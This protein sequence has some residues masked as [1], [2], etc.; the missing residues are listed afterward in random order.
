MSEE[1]D[2]YFQQVETLMGVCTGN[3]MYALKMAHKNYFRIKSGF[4]EDENP[5]DVSRELCMSIN[6][7]VVDG[8]VDCNKCGWSWELSDGGDDPYVCH[9]CGNKNN[10][11]NESVINERSITDNPVRTV[12]K[13]LI[14]IIK[15]QKPGIYELPDFIKRNKMEY[16]FPKLPLFSVVLDLDFQELDVPY[17]LDAGHYGEVEGDDEEGYYFDDEIEIA[18][19]INPKDYPQNLYDILADLNDSV[20]HE[21]EHAYQKNFRREIEF[22]DNDAPLDKEYYK[23]EK[24]IPA[25]IAGF[26]RIVKLR[27]EPVEKVIRD[28]FYRHKSTHELPN[29]DIEELVVFLSDKYRDFYGQ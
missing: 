1:F 19:V 18:L 26:R 7:S 25:E 11:L 22:E 12:V 2:D 20:R 14:N 9:K 16:D 27:N 15:L 24:E 3:D 6:E 23:Q 17:I 21:L 13:D 28:W 5:E 8:T 29:E 4:Y 10:N